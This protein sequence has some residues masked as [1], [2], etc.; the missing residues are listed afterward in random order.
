MVQ[1]MFNSI[2]STVVLTEDMLNVYTSLAGSSPAWVFMF[3][4]ALADA[5]VKEGLS[6]SLAYQIAARTLAG[7]AR[8]LEETGEH[9]AVL[10]DK[11]CSPAGTTIEAVSALESKGFRGSCYGGCKSLY[12][13][14]LPKWKKCEG[15]ETGFN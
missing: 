7:S 4:E 2:G 9:P 8:L 15:N 14:G 3:I 10:K 13:P 5:A 12:S 1:E 6:R 11:V